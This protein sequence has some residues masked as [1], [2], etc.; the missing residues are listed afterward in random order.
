MEV[1][2]QRL[3]SAIRAAQTAGFA[4]PVE[5]EINLENGF[6]SDPLPPEIDQDPVFSPA[7]L[8][9]NVISLDCLKELASSQLFG[10]LFSWHP[11]D[12]TPACCR[13][14]R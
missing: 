12:F 5:K 14:C 10:V 11:S 6:I 8:E 13:W 9:T 4:T 7:N 2:P 1:T 3:Q